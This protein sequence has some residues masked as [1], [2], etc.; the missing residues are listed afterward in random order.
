[1]GPSAEAQLTANHLRSIQVH[2]TGYIPSIGIYLHE[3][4]KDVTGRILKFSIGNRQHPR[5]IVRPLYFR[6]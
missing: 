1:M 3:F 4:M 5:H 2:D 6:A